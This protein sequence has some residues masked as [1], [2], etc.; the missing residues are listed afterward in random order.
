MASAS[1][2]I[3]PS[4]FFTSGDLLADAKT[5]NGQ[6]NALDNQ[7]W[8]APPKDLFDGFQA[9]MSEWRG[10][11]TDTFGGFFNFSALN[12][13]NRD[14]LIQFE[15]RF[16]TFARQYQDATHKELPG[17]VIA[18]STGAKDGFADQ[19]LNQLQPLIPQFSIGNIAL[20]V[21]VVAIGAA[22]YIFRAPIARAFKG[23]A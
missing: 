9:F 8:D 10:F 19:L 13:S 17:G 20:V 14:Q 18:P 21:G 6:I 11:Y 15:N 7:N 23:A 4:D 5:L 1:Y 3:G 2:R 12:D 22:L 16:A